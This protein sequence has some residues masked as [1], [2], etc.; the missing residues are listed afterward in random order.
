MIKNIRVVVGEEGG[1]AMRE[2]TGAG[3]Q[4]LFH[5]PISVCNMHDHIYTL[6]DAWYNYVAKFRKKALIEA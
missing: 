2:S 1:D 3:W 5:D 4:H 6:R